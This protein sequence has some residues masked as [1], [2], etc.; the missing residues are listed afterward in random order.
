MKTRHVYAVRDRA[1]L[2]AALR[3]VRALGVADDDL[4]IVA[5][6]D[7]ELA[8]NPDAMHDEHGRLTGLIAGL[9]AVAVPTL[10]ISIAGAGMLNLLGANLEGWVPHIAGNNAEEDVRERFEGRIAAGEILLVVEAAPEM[11]N[12]VNAAL[13]VER[14]EP[15]KFGD[16]P[17][18]PP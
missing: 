6:H 18:T 15:L 4:S 17:G 2:D 16:D 10:G 5:R 14:A 7:I 3:A 9:N 12:A 8:V 11:H 13:I 1:Q